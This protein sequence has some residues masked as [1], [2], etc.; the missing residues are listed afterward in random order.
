MEITS[1]EVRKPFQ[2]K[3]NYFPDEFDD[4]NHAFLSF[5]CHYGAIV[6]MLCKNELT[7]AFAHKLLE[8]GLISTAEKDQAEKMSSE[9]IRAKTIV[10]SVA[11]VVKRGVKP[12]ILLEKFI[13]VLQTNDFQKYF[14]QVIR[15]LTQ[16]GMLCVYLNFIIIIDANNIIYFYYIF[17][18]YKI[19]D[20]DKIIAARTQYP[21]RHA[22]RVIQKVGM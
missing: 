21:T 1:L 12:K 17:T 9:I 11:T 10:G 15:E 4:Q 8:V 22:G 3:K 14:G 19:L 7:M 13:G 20:V 16:R 18:D 6:D 2:R 5:D